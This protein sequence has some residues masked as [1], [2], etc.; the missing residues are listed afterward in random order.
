MKHLT[1]RKL[2]FFVAATMGIVG[3]GDDG[4]NGSDGE[5][6]APSVPPTAEK[7]K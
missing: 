6:G 7:P 2:A 3:C 4:K 1:K 5:D